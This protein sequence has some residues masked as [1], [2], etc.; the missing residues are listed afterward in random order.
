MSRPDPTAGMETG[1]PQLPNWRRWLVVVG[2]GL[3]LMSSFSILFYSTVPFFLSPLSAEFG[4]SR[5]HVSTAAVLASLGAAVSAPFMG[6]LFAR[7]GAERVIGLSVVL[8][9]VALFGFTVVPG[10]LVAFG[11]LSF[12]TGVVGSGT[13]MV[14]YMTVVTRWFDRRLGLA[15]GLAGIGLGLGVGLSPFIAAKLIG[16]FGW[17]G[18]YA[19][20][21]CFALAG[22]LAALWLV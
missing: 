21:S 3:G 22:G 19:G 10:N 4:W 14:G 18:A 12:C 2:A 9:A 6:K 5:A 7:F 17:R 11:A 20:F 15:M 1:L 16:Q 13:T 8:L